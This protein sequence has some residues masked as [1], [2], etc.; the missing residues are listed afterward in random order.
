[1]ILF[2][3]YPP[4]YPP[5]TTAG[6]TPIL[7]LGSEHVGE[8]RYVPLPVP[9]GGTTMRIAIVLIACLAGAVPA[10]ATVY[11]SSELGWSAAQDVTD[12]L[13][14]FLATTAVAGDE[15]RLEQVYRVSGA[16]Q[17]PDDFTLSAELGA[18]FDVTDAESDQN[19]SFLHL[20]NGNTLRNLTITY[21]NTPPPGPGGTSSVRGVDFYPMV[22]ITVTDGTDILIDSCELYGSV[23]HHLKVAGG[24]QI[25]VLGTHIVGGYWTVYLGGNVTD[26]VFR[27]CVIEQCQGDGIKTGRGGSYG[28]K[29]VLVESCLFQDNGRDG[30][31][32]TGGFMDSTV[33]DSIFRRLFSGMDIKS[34]FESPE[35]L[36]PDC[37]NT[38]ILVEGCTFTDMGSAIAMST[39]DRGLEYNGVYFLDA[40]SAQTYAPHDLDINDCTF[41]RTGDSDIRMLL[42]KG[43]HTVRYQNAMLCGEGVG[44]VRYTN[45]YETFGPA[46]LSQ[47]VSEALN[48]SV[49]GTLA[50]PCDPGAPGET[51]AP[52]TF[53]P[54]DLYGH[55]VAPG[56]DTGCGCTAIPRPTDASFLG[57]LILG[58]LAWHRHRHTSH[59]HRSAHCTD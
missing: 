37:M 31:D 21:L 7:D 1:M 43:G 59:S 12:E 32:T 45:V 18:G 8:R 46:T 48:H 42:M 44:E 11:H 5:L 20:G 51:S 58:L 26:V 38:G 9:K 35:H 17:L 22:G 24:S 54:Q 25:Q 13:A 52:F 3:L 27:N 4:L 36:T 14:E 29:R 2:T 6:V 53:G 47:E 56:D 19:R 39:I 50:P 41:E 33:R 16:H 49:T 23:D 57:L 55:P 15:L 34:Y 30:I 10:H 40:Q 28:V